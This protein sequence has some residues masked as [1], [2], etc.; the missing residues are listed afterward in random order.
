M[1]RQFECYQEGCEFMVRADTTDE[2]VALVRQ[3]AMDVHGL[4]LAAEDIQ[5][6]VETA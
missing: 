1:A 4:E 3:H 5:P 2:V 6:E